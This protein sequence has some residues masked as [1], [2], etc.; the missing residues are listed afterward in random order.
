MSFTD[1]PASCRVLEKSGFEL[2]GVLRKSAIKKG[3]IR[4][5]SVYARLK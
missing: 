4:D 5:V 1:N 2:E 3:K